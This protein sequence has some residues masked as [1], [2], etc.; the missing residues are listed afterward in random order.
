MKKGKIK[1]GIVLTVIGILIIIGLPLAMIPLGYGLLWA[2]IAVAVV[3]CIGF[4]M[5][6]IGTH[7]FNA[8]VKIKTM[9]LPMAGKRRLLEIWMQI[10]AALSSSI[11]VFVII[12]GMGRVGY[13]AHGLLW[14]LLSGIGVNLVTIAMATLCLIN[15]KRKGVSTNTGKIIIGLSVYTIAIMLGSIYAKINLIGTD[16]ENTWINWG[17]NTLVLIPI[18]ILAYRILTNQ[19][20]TAAHKNPE[21]NVR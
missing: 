4:G 1:L 9:P 13:T 14:S 6:L 21:L 19:K 12:G 16:W 11:Y 20:P 3:F 2:L 15:Q 5:I 17:F 8:E 18:L 7:L 10:T